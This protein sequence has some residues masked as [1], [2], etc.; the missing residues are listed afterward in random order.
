MP[1]RERERERKAHQLHP[2]DTHGEDPSL[3]QETVC[4]IVRKITL[5]NSPKDKEEQQEG[6]QD[7][8]VNEMEF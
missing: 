4:Y 7:R 6:G 5:G 1:V 3:I 2:R 8:A